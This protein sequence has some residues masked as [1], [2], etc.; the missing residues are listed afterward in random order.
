MISY[1]ITEDREKYER[2][3]TT[4]V[5][6]NCVPIGKPMGENSSKSGKPV[7]WQSRANPEREGVETLR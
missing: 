7:K 4:F 2:V 6:V 3:S 5:I 1:T